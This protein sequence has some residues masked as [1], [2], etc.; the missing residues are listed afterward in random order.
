MVTRH[1][2]L[3]LA[4]IDTAPDLTDYWLTHPWQ[5]ALLRTMTKTAV[6]ICGWW[7]T[8]ETAERE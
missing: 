1:H 7:L 4:L 8:R 3:A 5:L 6:L 2:I